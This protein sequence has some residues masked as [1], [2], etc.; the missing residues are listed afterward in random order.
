[1]VSLPFVSPFASGENRMLMSALSPGPTSVASEPVSMV[2]P[3][4]LLSSVTLSAPLTLAGVR[5]RRGLAIGEDVHHRV[6]LVVDGATA[7]KFSASAITV[8]SGFEFMRPP[9]QRQRSRRGQRPATASVRF[10]TGRGV[11]PHAP[12]ATKTQEH[13]RKGYSGAR[14]VSPKPITGKS[15]PSTC[16]STR[17]GAY[18]AA[19]TYGFE[20]MRRSLDEKAAVFLTLSGAMTPAGLHQSCLIPLIEAGIISASPR[21]ARTCT[22]TPTASSATQFAR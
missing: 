17:F 1:M 19:R 2:K 3:A 10:F 13:L 6:T 18:V 14:R 22:T 4:S 5:H 11:Y 20:L 7:L 15:R 12:M 8:K 16:S 21:P 9:S